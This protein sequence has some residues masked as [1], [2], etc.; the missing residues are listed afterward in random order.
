MPDHHG[1]KLGQIQGRTAAEANDQIRAAP[2]PN[3]SM[4]RSAYVAV[5]TWFNEDETMNYAAIRAQVRWQVA[6][7]NNIMC[8][9]TNGDFSA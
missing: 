2:V 4:T 9:G 3:C 8:E 7:G 6:A 1:H 5:V